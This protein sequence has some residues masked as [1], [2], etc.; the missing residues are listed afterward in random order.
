MTGTFHLRREAMKIS[1]PAVSAIPPPYVVQ[2]VNFSNGEI[3]LAG[4]LTHPSSQRPHP[5][6]ILLT[7]S[8]PQTRD[9]DIFG[10]SVFAT[11]ADTLTRS[12]MA[13]LRFDDR[14]VGGST[15]SLSEATTRDYASDALA[16]FTFLSTHP[17]IDKTKIGILG[18][19]EGGAAACFAAAREP[20]VAFL[21]LMAGPSVPG[22]RLILDQIETLGRQAGMPAAEIQDNMSLQRRVYDVLRSD[23]GW[24]SL[25]LLL[26]RHI[27]RR[28]PGADSL[29]RLQVEGQIRVMRSRWFRSFID[30]DPATALRE[31]F[32]PIL[33]LLG[34]KDMQVPPAT[35]R[36]VFEALREKEGR[37]NLTVV[38]IPGANHLFQNAGTRHPGEYAV[39]KKEFSGEFIGALISWV[40][41]HAGLQH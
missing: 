33:A 18:H 25:R 22:D 39:L 30:L 1:R 21:V 9:E 5:A 28:S 29:V 38:V 6:V 10:F 34:E 24:D 4:T 27:Q 35:N 15:G 17:A 12:G 40:A 36:A 37:K 32:V 14:G 19:S 41:K 23:I 20:A 2:E 13:V 8:G 26:A 7:G 16:A 31:V 3:S 11:L